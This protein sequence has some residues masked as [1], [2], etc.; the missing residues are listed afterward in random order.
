M[1]KVLKFIFCAFLLIAF[2]FMGVSYSD[3]VKEAGNWLFESKSEEIDFE[4]LEQNNPD[5]A[6]PESTTT[7]ANP[8]S[9][10]IDDNIE[11]TIIMDNEGVDSTETE[12]TVPENKVVN[13]AVNSQAQPTPTVP[14]KEAVP[15]AVNNTSN[16]SNVTK[17]K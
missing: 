11:P 7:Q 4:S 14:A 16:P 6:S 1:V 8:Q 17:K 10:I 9:D 12:G 13:P 5:T 15:A 2:F 3:Q